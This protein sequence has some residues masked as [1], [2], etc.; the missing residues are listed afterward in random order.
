MGARTGRYIPRFLQ[1]MEFDSPALRG[2][3][4]LFCLAQT[5]MP[6]DD[7]AERLI[8]ENL[9]EAAQGRKPRVVPIGTLTNAQLIE[10]NKH[11]RSRNWEDITGEIVFCGKH[12]YESRVVRDGYSIDDVVIQI[13]NAMSKS[14]R[15]RVSPKMTVIENPVK[16]NDQCGNRVTDQAVLECTSKFPRAELF[17]VIP[18]GDTN[19]P[20]NQN[21]KT[22]TADAIP[23]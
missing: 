3:F 21:K 19:K 4:N 2:T 13:T 5:T 1:G 7:N 20:I 8:R 17:S 10:I 9:N 22:G 14:S 18:S 11:R 15:V 12:V 16:R 23:V 6:L